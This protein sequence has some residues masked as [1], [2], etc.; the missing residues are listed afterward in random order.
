M[1]PRLQPHVS[2][3]LL[4]DGLHNA[5]NGVLI[6]VAAQGCSSSV[7]WVVATG[8]IIH[9]VSQEL[10]DYLLLVTRGNLG[11]GRALLLNWLSSLTCPLLAGITA[12]TP[13]STASLGSLLA[14]SAGFYIFLGATVSLAPLLEVPH[15]RE[16]L[17]ALVCFV[18]GASAIGLAT[19]NHQHCEVASDDHAGHGH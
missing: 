5:V 19:L 14:L 12:A 16:Q 6:G 7:L 4:G 18:L 2:Q 13:F 1:C 15:A 17:L 11:L 9:E 3:V 10:S 8:A